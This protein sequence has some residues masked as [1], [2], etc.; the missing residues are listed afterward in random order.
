[1]KRTKA[2]AEGLYSISLTETI[3]SYGYGARYLTMAEGDMVLETFKSYSQPDIKC[4]LQCLMSNPGDL[5]PLYLAEDPNLYWPTIWYYGSVYSA[6]LTCC[7]V[8]IV[9]KLYG[10]LSRYR[11]NKIPT[12]S[13]AI[14][15]TISVFP[16]F[17]VGETRK[18]CGN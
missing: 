18:A 15:S 13:P 11:S 6:L 1:M 7:G 16:S 17:A 9:K 4:V 10:K 8:I 12:S 14:P 5:H 3:P 2:V